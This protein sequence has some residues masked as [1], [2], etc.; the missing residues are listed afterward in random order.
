MTYGSHY[1]TSTATKILLLDIEKKKSLQGI[2]KKYSETLIQFKDHYKNSHHGDEKSYIDGLAQ[3]CTPLLT[4]WN[5]CSLT[6]SP[7]YV[8]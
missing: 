3:D 8:S 5:C 4:H 1:K 6:L 7:R 2:E